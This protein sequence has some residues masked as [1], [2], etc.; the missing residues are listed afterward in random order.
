[1]LEKYKYRYDLLQKLGMDKKDINKMILKQLLFYFAIPMII[2]IFIG[3]PIT[4]IVSR[5]VL[6]AVTIEEVIR[7]IGIILGI[8]ILVYGIYFIA[9]YIQ[10]NRNIEVR[11]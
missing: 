10:F 11:R 3:I 8:F 7:N 1:M 4:L 2:P 5:T 9:T 6:S